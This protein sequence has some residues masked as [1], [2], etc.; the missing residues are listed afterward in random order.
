MS[1]KISGA[2]GGGFML[3]F[4]EPKYRGKLI[5]GLEK[6]GAI[7]FEYNFETKGVQSWSI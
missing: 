7:H 6:L 4:T 5:E 3:F 2:G 1:G